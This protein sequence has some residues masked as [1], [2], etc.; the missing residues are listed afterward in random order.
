MLGFANSLF[1]SRK[2]PRRMYRVN[3]KYYSLLLADGDSVATAT[4]AI[5]CEG[6]LCRS[7]YAMSNGRGRVLRSP[8]SLFSA[9]SILSLLLSDRSPPCRRRQFLELVVRVWEIQDSSR[10]I[11][12]HSQITTGLPSFN[13]SVQERRTLQIFHCKITSFAF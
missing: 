1:R 5:N 9:L 3:K 4:H 13:T 6:W 7:V 8:S 12:F 10:T 11:L 2:P